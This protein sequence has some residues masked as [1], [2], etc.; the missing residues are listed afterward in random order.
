MARLTVSLPG[1]S[2]RVE[3]IYALFCRDIVRT[4][5]LCAI[6]FSTSLAVTTYYSTSRGVDLALWSHRWCQ[7]VLCGVES[8]FFGAR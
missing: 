3:K 8:E 4:I 2:P 7:K 5:Y 6:I 1:L